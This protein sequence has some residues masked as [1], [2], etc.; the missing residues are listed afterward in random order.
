MGFFLLAFFFEVR[1]AAEIAPL[2]PRLCKEERTGLS[3]SIG[4]GGIGE[5]QRSSDHSLIYIF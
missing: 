1:N 4:E 5:E 2:N 3:I